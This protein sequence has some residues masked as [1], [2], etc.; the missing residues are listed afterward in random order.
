[1]TISESQ[2][3]SNTI[4]GT[5]IT[6]GTPTQVLFDSGSSRSF[7][8]TL[9]ALHAD[10]ELSLVKY[11]LVVTTLF[12]EQI[13]RNFIFKDCEILIK[14]VALKMNLIPLEMH[15]FDVILGMDWLSTHRDSMDYF[16]KKVV[17]QK[18]KFS[19]LE[20]KGDRRILPHVC[21]LSHRGKEI[22]T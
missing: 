1:M 4:S 5:M 18:S 3:N 6:F 9:F 14:G 16:T 22:A 11:K 12:G 21:D 20:F 10:Q 7:I 8:S 15:D 13:L 2:A 19:A 17:F